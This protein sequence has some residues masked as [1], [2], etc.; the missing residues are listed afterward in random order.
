MPGVPPT[1]DLLPVA[2]PPPAPKPPVF[3]PIA[4]KPDVLELA[5]EPKPEDA[6]AEAEVC[7]CCSGF[8]D[9][10]ADPRLANGED[11]DVFAKPDPGGT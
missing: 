7:G 9:G 4:P 10:V 3:F 1:G 11:A 6:N 8:E 5:I 2:K